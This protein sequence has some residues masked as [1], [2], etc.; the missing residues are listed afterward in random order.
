MSSPT[1]QLSLNDIAG[2][3]EPSMMAFARKMREDF[4]RMQMEHQFGVDEVLTKVSILQ[5][6]FMHLHQYNP[7]EHVGSRIKTTASI[8]EKAL[9]RDLELTPEA[10]RAGITDIAGIRITCSFI[11]DTYRVLETLTSQSDVQVLMIKDYIQSP[12]PNG[13]QSLHAI[14]QIP[15]FLS[16]GPVPVT[17]EVQIRT[18]AMD[19]WA[20]LDHKIHYKYN[21]AVPDHLS[22]SLVETADIASQ[23]DRR[24][25][26]LHQEVRGINPKLESDDPPAIDGVDEQLLLRLWQRSWPGSVA[27]RDS[28]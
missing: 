19:F 22:A 8:L 25:E 15:V 5:R 18:I 11:S 9:R 12:K 1:P 13:Y 17:V 2:A 6:E 27:E 10:I 20:S 14:I 4:L 3:P 26:Q 24:M 23:L 7:I 28:A 21:G 16:S